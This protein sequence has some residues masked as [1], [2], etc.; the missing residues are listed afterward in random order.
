MF[1]ELTYFSW[2]AIGGGV[3]GLIVALI[4]I[5]AAVGNRNRDK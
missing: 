5:I 4:F 2:P 3:G 1:A